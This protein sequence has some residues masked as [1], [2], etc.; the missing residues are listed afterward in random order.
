MTPLL[1]LLM[2][3]PAAAQNGV[4]GVFPLSAC[5]L[6]T[7]PATKYVPAYD[8][9]AVETASSPFL[10][11][12]CADAAPDRRLAMAF[13]KAK[14]GQ[15]PTL[16]EPLSADVRRLEPTRCGIL[17]GAPADRYDFALVEYRNPGDAGSARFFQVVRTDKRRAARKM[18]YFRRYPGDVNS[19]VAVKAVCDYDGDA[20]PDVVIDVCGEGGCGV[21]VLFLRP[22]TGEIDYREIRA[23]AP[24]EQ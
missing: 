21:S 4:M 24:V 15:D 23:P 12:R 14:R 17:E 7:V 9:V 6:K 5:A 16:L 22:K 19:R 3:A 13:R 8:D 11:Q 20:F 1:L 18:I 10:I 2:A